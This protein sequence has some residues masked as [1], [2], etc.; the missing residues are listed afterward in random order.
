[1]LLGVA[2]GDGEGTGGG[3]GGGGLHTSLYLSLFENTSRTSAT[4]LFTSGY[5]KL[6]SFSLMVPRSIG[7]VTSSK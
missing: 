1:M 7:V 5:C 6:L 3:G 4:K 2:R